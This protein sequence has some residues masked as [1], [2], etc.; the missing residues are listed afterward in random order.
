MTVISLKFRYFKKV[1]WTQLSTKLSYFGQILCND[2]KSHTDYAYMSKIALVV[3][4]A[5]LS[6]LV[7]IMSSVF[8]FCLCTYLLIYLLTYLLTICTLCA[9]GLD[10]DK[11]LLI[12]ILGSLSSLVIVIISVFVVCVCVRRCRRLSN[13]AQHEE[14]AELDDSDAGRLSS[15]RRPPTPA[16][17]RWFP[18]YGSARSRTYLPA[19]WQQTP[20][21]PDVYD[22][23]PYGDDLS[24]IV[25]FSGFAASTLSTQLSR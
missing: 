19:A 8:I 16:G 23:E 2:E 22:W 13:A 21:R 14:V 4:L 9:G 11:L 1:F 15:V 3:V 5:T 20:S 17:L 7:I 12:I 18:E 25:S 24:Q 10:D 6:S